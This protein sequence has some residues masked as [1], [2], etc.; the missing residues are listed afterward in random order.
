MG[1]Q[2]SVWPFL[3]IVYAG[4]IVVMCAVNI[5][6]NL[7]NTFRRLAVT[8]PALLP[9]ATNKKSTLGHGRL[10]EML[11]T[12]QV[13]RWIG[14]DQTYQTLDLDTRGC[15]F[16]CGLDQAWM[17]MQK[18]SKTSACSVFL[19]S[20]LRSHRREPLAM[21][22][23]H[24]HSAGT[25]YSSKHAQRCLFVVFVSSVRSPRSCISYII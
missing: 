16:E 19:K 8:S 12:S 2:C 9:L 20:D 17:R 1:P 22:I 5:L 11:G 25:E 15:V 10:V 23:W 13:H 3:R 21:W 6:V 24:E 18:H 4:T 7:F 14:I